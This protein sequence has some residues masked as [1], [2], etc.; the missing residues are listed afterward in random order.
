MN[1]VPTDFTVLRGEVLYD[2]DD[3][4][5]PIGKMPDYVN[6]V[7]H[8]VLY[9][10]GLLSSWDS[11][12]IQ[13]AISDM[14]DS[15]VVHYSFSHSIFMS[16]EEFKIRFPNVPIPDEDSQSKPKYIFKKR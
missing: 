12:Y 11:S 6:V 7:L 10:D 1:R 4:D 9:P 2:H 5:L 8:L 3:Q 16:L 15:G 14:L 13:G